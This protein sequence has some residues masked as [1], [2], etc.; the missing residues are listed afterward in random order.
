MAVMSTGMEG[1]DHP[2]FLPAMSSPVLQ[3][4]FEVLYFSIS[5]SRYFTL[6]QFHH[7]LEVTTVLL[8]DSFS[9]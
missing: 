5:I 1:L 2:Y 3:Y 4:N 6:I 7:M 9:Y 8:P